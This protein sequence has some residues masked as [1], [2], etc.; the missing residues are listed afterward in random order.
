MHPRTLPVHNGSVIAIHEPAVVRAAE[1]R[2]VAAA[3]SALGP[4][5]LMVRAARGVSDA[6]ERLAGSTA[7]VLVLVGGG[8][9]GGDALYAAS[10][11]AGAGHEVRVLLLSTHP[12]ERGLAAACAQGV[13]VL[14]P[15]LPLSEADPAW[16]AA[17]CWID[18]L[19][20]TGL[21][22]A[23]R[24]PLAGAVI[25]LDA[26]A[27]EA[28]ALVIA[29]DVPSGIGAADGTVV[30]PVLH[31]RHTVTMGSAKTPGFLPPAALAG[32]SVELVDLGILIENTPV[33][34]RPTAHDVAAALRVPGPTDHKYTRGVVTIAAG[35]DTFPGAGVLATAGALGVGPGMARLESG[36]RTE[37]V[38]L[39]RHPGVVTA[40][41]RSQACLIGSGLDSEMEPTARTVV[42]RALTRG[43]PLV[44]DAGGLN[45]VPDLMDEHGSL[46]TVVLTPHAGE[47]ATLLSE[48][49][50]RTVSRAEVEAAPLAALRSLRDFTGAVVLLKGSV[51]LV[52]GPD[53]RVFSVAGAPGWT[54]VAGA[55][56]VLAGVTAS[57]LAQREARIE[58][59]A[60]T[61][62]AREGGVP[63]VDLVEAAAHAAWI[64][65][66]A[67][68]LA[69]R[70]AGGELLG[71]LA[72]PE[73]VLEPEGP[74]HPGAPIQAEEIAAQLP[75]VIGALL[76]LR[77]DDC[78]RARR[79]RW[80]RED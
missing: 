39:E 37:R 17:D 29:I 60:I 6:V 42:E 31:A 38:V 46:P 22:G 53:G 25:R 74:T 40:S 68:A 2:A 55:G 24:D 14:T 43:I 69:S 5:A 26:L 15:E 76:D 78:A 11:L 80:S 79:A 65:G 62:K 70:L 21:T 59:E 49:S 56:D 67:A 73:M 75:H 16:A 61:G 32:G 48:L 12:H 52:S 34:L 28:G 77:E 71:S 30:G 33:A 7:T 51:T 47:A 27:C 20:G 44:M 1:A 4:D 57:L 19:T 10:Y 18:G 50:G 64:H 13:L 23:L 3:E 58:S 41:G 8:D 9:N 72:E 63:G 54:G 36:G 66:R 35:S 45:M